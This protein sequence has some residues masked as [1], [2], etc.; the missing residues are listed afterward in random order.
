MDFINKPAR[1]LFSFSLAPAEIPHRS[2]L[3]YFSTPLKSCTFHTWGGMTGIL[4]ALDREECVPDLHV[5]PGCLQDKEGFRHKDWEFPWRDENK[6]CG[7]KEKLLQGERHSWCCAKDCEHSLHCRSCLRAVTFADSMSPWVIWLTSVYCEKICCLATALTWCNWF[8]C[9]SK[10]MFYSLVAF[11]CSCV[12]VHP[13]FLYQMLL[14]G[15]EHLLLLLD[16]MCLCSPLIHIHTHR[17]LP[18]DEQA[19]ITAN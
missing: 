15:C 4:P 6:Y 13:P 7:S 1:C 9:T 2:N 8:F 19:V 12:W 18:W 17:F 16:Y 14:S 3:S 5:H 11:L 10:T